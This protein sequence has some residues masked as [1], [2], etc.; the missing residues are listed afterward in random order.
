MRQESLS[1]TTASHGHGSIFIAGG[2]YQVFKPTAFKI[3]GGREGTNG[4]TIADQRGDQFNAGSYQL[5]SGMILACQHHWKTTYF[6]SRPGY[7]QSG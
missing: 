1:K 6:H 4:N 3:V 2:G 7:Q 5:N